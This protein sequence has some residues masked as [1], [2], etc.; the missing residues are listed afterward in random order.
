[1]N[2]RLSPSRITF[3]IA[4]LALILTTYALFS[5]PAA[6]AQD[7]PASPAPEPHQQQS[8]NQNPRANSGTTLRLKVNL[9]PVP[10]V[11]R[12]SAGHAVGNLQ[13]ENFQ[14]FDNRKQ[15]QITNSH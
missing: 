7:P 10:V 2:A 6:T 12:D 14:L 4:T 15:Q 13:K 1:M 9:V 5:S 11:V 8:T 3:S